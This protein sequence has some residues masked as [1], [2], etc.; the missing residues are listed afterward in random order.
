VLLQ[1]L[2]IRFALKIAVRIRQLADHEPA[3]FDDVV[4]EIDSVSRQL[5][6]RLA[7]RFV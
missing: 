1:Q 6:G 3:G 2:A 7:E 4:H 5:I